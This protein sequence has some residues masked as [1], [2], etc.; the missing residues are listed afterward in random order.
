MRTVLKLPF[1]PSVNHYW[2]HRV[3]KSKTG[4]PIVMGYVTAKGKDFKKTVVDAVARYSAQGRYQ[5][6]DTLEVSVILFPPDRRRRDIDNYNKACFDA[7]SDSGLWVDDS[8]VKKMNLEMSEH[9]EN[10]LVIR[11]EKIA[12]QP[13][14]E[15]IL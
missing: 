10:C 14:Q 7:L 3:A 13:T 6:G 15:A 2:G 11:V 12:T 4:K 9:R 1:P 5:E 8:Q